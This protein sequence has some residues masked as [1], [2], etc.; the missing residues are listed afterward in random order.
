MFPGLRKAPRLSALWYQVQHLQALIRGDSDAT[1]SQ[2][3]AALRAAEI[4]FA[5]VFPH[6]PMRHELVM[7]W[8]A[9]GAPGIRA[10]DLPKG[11]STGPDAS[12]TSQGSQRESE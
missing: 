4:A 10:D 3:Q 1:G 2:R 5:R 9:D 7:A 8:L 11:L 6:L 12:Q